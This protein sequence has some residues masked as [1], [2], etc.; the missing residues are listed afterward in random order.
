M[1]TGLYFGENNIRVR[2]E[3]KGKELCAKTTIFINFEE[4]YAEHRNI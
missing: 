2:K 3:A 1:F 4:V